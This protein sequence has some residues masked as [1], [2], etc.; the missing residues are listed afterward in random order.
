MASSEVVMLHVTVQM[1]AV[2][3]HVHAISEPVEVC[4]ATLV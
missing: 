1:T 2:T 4:V 3:L